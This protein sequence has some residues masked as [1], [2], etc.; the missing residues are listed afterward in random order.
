MYVS[1]LTM[2]S[3]ISLSLVIITVEHSL[4]YLKFIYQF[5][6]DFDGSSSGGFTTTA[7]GL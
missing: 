7:T 2:L 3:L 1:I 6:V 4:A 5:S